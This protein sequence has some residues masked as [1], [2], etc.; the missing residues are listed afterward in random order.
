MRGASARLERKAPTAPEG[1][2]VAGDD[3][4]QVALRLQLQIE[5]RDA[6]ARDGLRVEDVQRERR[7][8]FVDGVVFLS[9]K[10]LNTAHAART[11][12]QRAR[13]S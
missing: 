1:P 5:H 10:L 9:V 11:K 2:R 4:V 12:A 6:L 8:G 3:Q 7:G 13:I